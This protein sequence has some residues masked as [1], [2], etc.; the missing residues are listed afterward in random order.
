MRSERRFEQAAEAVARSF[1]GAY[2][3]EQI[4]DIPVAGISDHVLFDVAR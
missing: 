3:L 2:L 4:F 1:Q